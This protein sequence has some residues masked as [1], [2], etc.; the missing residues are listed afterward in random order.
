MA[1]WR[2]LIGDWM[3]AELVVPS[4][5][6]EM[7]VIHLI[8]RCA[9]RVGI[10]IAY[11]A[12]PFLERRIEIAGISKLLAK[13]AVIFFVALH[14]AA[15][16]AGPPRAAGALRKRSGIELEYEKPGNS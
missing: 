15:K 16:G 4:H 13:L 10:R 2:G 3:T 12:T 9:D 1:G 8:K 14:G 6:V 11:A 7:T 5:I